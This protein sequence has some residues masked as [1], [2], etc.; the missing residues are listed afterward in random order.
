MGAFDGSAQI[1][2]IPIETR[3]PKRLKPRRFLEPGN[4]RQKPTHRS[5]PPSA[6]AFPLADRGTGPCCRPRVRLFARWQTS[7]R[8]NPSYSRLRVA[9]CCRSGADGMLR[10]NLPRPAAYHDRCHAETML[11]VALACQLLPAKM[12]KNQ[13]LVP[14]RNLRFCRGSYW[15]VP[16]NPRQ[17]HS[18]EGDSRTPGQTNE[19]RSRLARPIGVAIPRTGF[20]AMAVAVK[21]L[22]DRGHAVARPPARAQWRPTVEYCA[23]LPPIPHSA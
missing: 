22:F 11:S 8:S 12:I 16:E 5:Y 6:A 9:A 7:S 13:Y 19:I 15:R 23:P 18:T 4:F 3:D 14:D 1:C 17:F 20:G 2:A 10:R 21:L